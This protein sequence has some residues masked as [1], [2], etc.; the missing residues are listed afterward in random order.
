M[1]MKSGKALRLSFML[2]G[3]SSGVKGIHEAHQFR[4]KLSMLLKLTLMTVFGA[5][6]TR[7][8]GNA[9]IRV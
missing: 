5:K 7:M 8:L 2:L 3:K 6:W 1:L 4:G 9:Y